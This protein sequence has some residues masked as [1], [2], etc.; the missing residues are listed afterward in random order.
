VEPVAFLIEDSVEIRDSLIPALQELASTKVVAHAETEKDALTWLAEHP[1]DWHIA[2]VDLFLKEGSGLGVLA[3]S[4]PRQ[5]N[6][7]MVV[8]TN[9][10]TKDMRERCAKLGADAVF[11]KSNQLDEFFDF[12]LAQFKLGN[13]H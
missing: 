1:H 5:P 10:A 6:Q 8:L 4:G 13:P 3:L 11:D 7:R 2:V 12:C 9:Y